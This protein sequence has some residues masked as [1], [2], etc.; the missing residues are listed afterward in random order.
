MQYE[1]DLFD[2]IIKAHSGPFSLSSTG[3]ED[4]KLKLKEKHG[5]CYYIIVVRIRQNG[6]KQKILDKNSICSLNPAIESYNKLQLDMFSTDISEV[7][8][9]SALKSLGIRAN[10][11]ESFSFRMDAGVKTV[12][13][14][15]N[16]SC[17]DIPAYEA[18][19]Y[20]YNSLL[21]DE[22]ERI[23]R[24]ITSTI[25]ALNS[26]ENIK[27]YAH[28]QQRALTEVCFRIS[29]LLDPAI[30]HDI[31][32][33]AEEF[34]GNDILYLTYIYLE[35]LL[36]FFEIRFIEYVN[37]NIQVPLRSTLFEAYN[38]SD[39]YSAVNNALLNS[40]IDNSLLHII[41]QPLS[42]LIHVKPFERITYR[43]MIYLSN[44]LSAFHD[45]VKSMAQFSSDQV[46]DLLYRFNFNSLEL[47]RYKT[48]LIKVQLAG[49]DS[50]TRQ[51]DYLYGFLKTVNQRFC[52]FNFAFIPDLPS[53]KQQI[54]TWLE[55]EISFL[56][57]KLR[58]N[59]SAPDLFTEQRQEAVTK[60]GVNGTV[61]QLA[62]F[63]KTLTEVGFFSHRNQSDIIRHIVECYST[64]RVSDISV[65]SVRNKFYND[66]ETSKEAVRSIV[67]KMLNRL[68][69]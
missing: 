62:C 31:Y 66:D 19:Y 33:P 22:T 52:K 34:T 1:F 26:A 30:A 15:V 10:T 27:A 28:N 23:K 65:D 59:D 5:S 48:N 13:L 42:S 49:L 32:K 25:F 14:K 24:A 16:R 58:L 68:K 8:S 39:K 29:K 3:I 64:S 50:V 7:I 36:R 61:S 18:R 9:L 45:L 57:K 41:H 38:L 46:I 54:S 12:Y 44:L 56:S 55:E 20:Y 2:E 37:E 51:I 17:S 43:E 6:Q 53:L 69:T 40:G 63:Y 60:I 21:K 35:E 67:I 11:V 47:A 4:F